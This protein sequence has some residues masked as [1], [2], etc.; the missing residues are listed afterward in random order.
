MDLII[1][2]KDPKSLLSKN[3]FFLLQKMG[4]ERELLFMIL[5]LP[6]GEE[7]VLLG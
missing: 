2:T 3:I 4:L 6:I 5:E 1:K 7:R